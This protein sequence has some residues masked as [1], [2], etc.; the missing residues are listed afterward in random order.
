MGEK[1]DK[2]DTYDW[3]WECCAYHKN[4]KTECPRNRPFRGNVGSFEER[5]YEMEIEG[6]ID[7][8]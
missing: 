6:Q 4:G 5:E 1:T 7:G 8:S 3:C 2:P